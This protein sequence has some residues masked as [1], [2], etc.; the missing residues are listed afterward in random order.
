MEKFANL[1]PPVKWGVGVLGLA[2]L[3]GVGAAIMSGAWMFILVLVLLLVVI[4]GGYLLFTALRRKQRSAQPGGELAQ[5]SSASPRGISDPGQRAR[6][7]DMR[8][9]FETGVREYKSRGK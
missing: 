8:K 6:L 1:S 9:K 3:I 2:G 4:L 5:H 7:D